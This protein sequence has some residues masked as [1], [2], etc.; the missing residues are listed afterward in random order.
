ML[1]GGTQLSPENDSQN[2][3]LRV[4]LGVGGGIAAYKAAELVRRLRGAGCEVRCSLSRSAES[5][6]PPLTLEVLSEHPVFRQEYLT[7]T[8]RG[9]ESHIAAAQWADVV[10]LAPTT[11]HLLARFALG[12]ADDFL[13]TTLLAF[14]GPVVIAP[15]MHDAMWRKESVQQN[16]NIL[17]QRGVRRVGPEEG[18]LASGEWGMGR[19]SAPETIVRAVM[20]EGANRAEAADQTLSG[21]RVVVSAGPTHEALDP[22]RF[23]GNRSSGKMGFA[24][25]AEAAR[26]GAETTL[27]AGPVSLSTPAGVERVD[28]MSALEMRDAVFD[29]AR[30]ADVVIMTAA[31]ADFRPEHSE[32]SKIKKHQGIPKIAL[33]ANPDI[34]SELATVAPE[35]LRV[36]F[37]AETEVSE[38]EVW[39]KLE[40][41]NAHLLIWND[42][43]KKDIGFEADQNEVTVYRR[44]EAPVFF[45]RRPKTLLA[46]D[47]FN[48]FAEIL[49]HQGAEVASTVG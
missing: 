22:V 48:L 12:L 15:A 39:A 6:L 19:M 45:S 28:V 44:D 34:L 3:P 24:L 49:E 11:A 17:D 20:E 8:G 26:R 7:A 33:V 18:P 14:E 30:Q 23:L 46:V 36:G 9:E 47:L 43:S 16:V 25:A 35:A 38:D 1:S 29:H 31:V 32:V 21:L 27:V 13:T 4:L 41:K 2:R 10:C 42:V 37:A 5:F 40:R